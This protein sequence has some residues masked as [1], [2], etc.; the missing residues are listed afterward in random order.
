MHR[1]LERTDTQMILLLQTEG[2]HMGGT[3]KRKEQEHLEEEMPEATFCIPR[4]LL[5]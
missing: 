2:S 1:L 3:A 5:R 4:R